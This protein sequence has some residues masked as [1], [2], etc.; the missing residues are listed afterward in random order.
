MVV[1]G[2]G[3]GETPQ[4]TTKGATHV[5]KNKIYSKFEISKNRIK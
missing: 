5:G 2:E 4:K 1:V 3:A